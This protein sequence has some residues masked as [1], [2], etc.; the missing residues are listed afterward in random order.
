VLR[1]ASKAEK[2]WPIPS[3]SSS[4][5]MAGPRLISP[6]NEEDAD[7]LCLQLEEDDDDDDDSDDAPP[8]LTWVVS[9][10]SCFASSRIMSLST[11]AASRAR[12]PPR[13]VLCSPPCLF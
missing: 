10:F 8:L 12:A 4:P 7:F 11:F 2:G 1:V 6:S 9:C 13:F 3:A 5:H